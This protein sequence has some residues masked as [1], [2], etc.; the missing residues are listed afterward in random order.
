MQTKL[1]LY[2]DYLLSSFGQTGATG[3]SRLVDGEISHDSVTRFLSGNHFTP[4]T[5]WQKVK[6][7]V[8]QY[9]T[10]DACLIFDD[11]I[12]E[13]PFTHENAMNC[14][15]FDHSKNRN[16]KGMNILNAFYHTQSSTMDM[17]LR[18]PVSFEIILKT[19]LFCEIK[20]KK[21]KR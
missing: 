15:H 16:V 9:E 11:I 12:V 10:E 19:I 14:W 7:L 6:G 21:Q 17:P 3:L 13:K 20:T 5:L 18:V 2:T 8:R 1:D 4:K